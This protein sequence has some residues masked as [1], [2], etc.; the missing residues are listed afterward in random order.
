MQ[1]LGVD[2]ATIQSLVGHADVDMTKHYLHVQDSIRI[3]AIT[4]FDRAVSDEPE[5]HLNIID[6]MKSS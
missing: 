5:T 4:K 3:A 2:L 1:A 6:F